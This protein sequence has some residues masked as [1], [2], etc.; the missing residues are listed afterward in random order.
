[1]HAIECRRDQGVRVVEQPRGCLRLRYAIT[2]RCWHAFER[3]R[4][5]SRP[6]DAGE[7]LRRLS[8]CDP[9]TWNQGSA[10]SW[11]ERQMDPIAVHPELCRV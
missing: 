1:V 9:G 11:R 3:T 10:Q 6:A 7:L 2:D 4:T 8:N 5:A